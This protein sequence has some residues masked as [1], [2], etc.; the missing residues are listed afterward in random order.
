MLHSRTLSWVESL[1][2]LYKRMPGLLDPTVG[3]TVFQGVTAGHK[4]IELRGSPTK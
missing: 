2:Y 3:S 1:S 4:N